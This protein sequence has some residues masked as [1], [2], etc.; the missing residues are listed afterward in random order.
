[1]AIRG[2][3]AMV[4]CSAARPSG[5]GTLAIWRRI[6]SAMTAMSSS[7][8][9]SPGNRSSIASNVAA[10]PGPCVNQ[11]FGGSTTWLCHMPWAW[12]RYTAMVSGNMAM[13]PC[14]A[15]R[16]CRYQSRGMTS[17]GMSS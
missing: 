17:A 4:S 10:C 6:Q 8:A 16:T 14:T 15:C 5:P 2:W 9:G 11:N 13:S 1:M 7:R 3:R 12:R